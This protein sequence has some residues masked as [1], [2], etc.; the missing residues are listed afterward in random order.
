MKFLCNHCLKEM[1]KLRTPGDEI[2]NNLICKVCA[3]VVNN[4]LKEEKEILLALTY[5]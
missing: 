2:N 4:L 1:K 3:E 5:Q